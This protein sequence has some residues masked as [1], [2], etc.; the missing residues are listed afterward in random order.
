M[1]NQLEILFKKSFLIEIS[2]EVDRFVGNRTAIDN[3]KLMEQD[4]NFLLIGAT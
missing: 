3:F 4:E 2:G 1:Q